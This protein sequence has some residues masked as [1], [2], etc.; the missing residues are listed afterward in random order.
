MQHSELA[1]V[2]YTIS[3][4]KEFDQRIAQDVESKKYDATT[5]KTT[6]LEAQA[7]HPEKVCKDDHD[8]RKEP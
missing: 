3:P 8:L 2:L 5:I 6:Y 1:A 7:L 4:N